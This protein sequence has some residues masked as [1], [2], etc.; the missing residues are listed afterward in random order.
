MSGVV[1]STNVVQRPKQVVDAGAAHVMLED[2]T[3]NYHG[4]LGENC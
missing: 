1:A 3:L 2:G 4:I